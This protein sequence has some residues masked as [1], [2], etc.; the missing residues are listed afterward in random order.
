[1]GILTKP[2]FRGRSIHR[3]D[4]KGRLRIPSKYRDILKNHYTDA[5]VVA[6]LEG[7]L[8]AY[9]PERWEKLEEKAEH[10][11]D[12]HPKH[13][14]FMRWFISS[15]EECEFDNKGRIL[16][17]PFFRSKAGLD[18]EVILVGVLKGFEIWDVA[19]WESHDEWNRSHYQEILEGIAAEGL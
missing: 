12:V 9:P 7:C 11:S 5:L 6:L 2:Y 18:S 1:M 4:A 3:L 14:A 13:R 16:L 15:A 10:L 8:V 19:A 17:S